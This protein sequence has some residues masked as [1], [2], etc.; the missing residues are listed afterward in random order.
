MMDDAWLLAQRTKIE[1]IKTEIKGMEAM[2]MFRMYL[3]ES[4]AYTD[5]AFNEKAEALRNI[6]LLILRRENTWIK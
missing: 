1:A 3:G 5:D 6:A 2:N 4:L